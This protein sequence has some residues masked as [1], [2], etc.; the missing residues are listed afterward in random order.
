MLAIAYCHILVSF[1]LITGL[2]FS[3]VM[4]YFF[5]PRVTMLAQYMRPL[6]VCPY[7]CHKL[8]LYQNA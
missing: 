2:L 3:C 7:A 1:S 6:C 5:L 8:A 4:C